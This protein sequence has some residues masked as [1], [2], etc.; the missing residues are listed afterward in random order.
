MILK[1]QDGPKLKGKV[2]VFR[3]YLFNFWDPFILFL[4]AL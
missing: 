3:F 2:S 4:L 1:L